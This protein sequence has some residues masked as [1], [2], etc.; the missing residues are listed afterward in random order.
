M[1]IGQIAAA[2]V[3]ALSPFVPFLVDTGKAAGKKNDGD[4]EE[5]VL[6]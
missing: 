5:Q 6:F 3:M 2:V 4:A 1:D